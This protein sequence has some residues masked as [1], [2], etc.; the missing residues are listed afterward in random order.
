MKDSTLA[1]RAV[2]ATMDL[3]ADNIHL[4]QSDHWLSD[5]RNVVQIHLTQATYGQ[6]GHGAVTVP[7]PQ[8]RMRLWSVRAV[9]SFFKGADLEGPANTFFAHG[10]AGVDFLD[11]SQETLV[12]DFRMSAFAAKKVLAA[13]AAYIQQGS[14]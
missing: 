10:V 2:V 7:S 5:R 3:S 12:N 4:L 13:R 6:V 8:E 14:S 11:I 9:G 1:R